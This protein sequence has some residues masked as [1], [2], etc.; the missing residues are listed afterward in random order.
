MTLL[1]RTL[2]VVLACAPFGCARRTL[3]SPSE[4]TT[5]VE[6]PARSA[7]RSKY[8]LTDGRSVSLRDGHVVFADYAS[9]APREVAS[10]PLA[11][12]TP[13][14][15]AWGNADLCDVRAA[16]MRALVRCGEITDSP[17]GWRNGSLR[18][19]IVPQTGASSGLD[20]L[21]APTLVTVSVE[22]TYLG[23][24]VVRGGDGSFEPK[25]LGLVVHDATGTRLSGPRIAA[26]S[27]FVAVTTLSMVR[28]KA[29]A[30]EECASRATRL[31]VF[32]LEAEPYAVALP[33]EE[34]PEA[35]ARE[36]GTMRF[37]ADGL[38][39]GWATHEVADGSRAFFVI[40]PDARVAREVRA[41]GRH[42]GFVNRSL[43]LS[44]DPSGEDVFMSRDGGAHWTVLA[45]FEEEAPR[46]IST[47]SEEAEQD[48][49]TFPP[50]DCDAFGCFAL[51]RYFR[52]VATP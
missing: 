19:V 49:E 26:C 44:H 20:W 51:G 8:R 40:D 42:V 47:D 31:H 45:H 43:G 34:S 48:F 14:L 28:T 29:L 24:V 52:A 11:P 10:V 22:G 17:G 46:G 37:T 25:T 15:A 12:A 21:D 6:A 3:P 18:Y 16:G 38:A 30:L 50:V 23:G 2:A 1:L 13:E 9:G 5:F 32:T 7:P 39:Y 36:L 41:P 27:D 33:S 35:R 4:A